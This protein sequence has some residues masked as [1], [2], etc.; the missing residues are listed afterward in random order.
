[1]VRKIVIYTITLTVMLMLVAASFLLG[2]AS[3]DRVLGLT[4]RLHAGKRQVLIREVS[5]GYV[6]EVYAH[7]NPYPYNEAVY[8]SPDDTC[9]VASALLNERL[10]KP[11]WGK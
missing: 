1:M 9:I 11:K 4:G 5:N 6:V 8:D 10:P 3:A 2:V 7:N